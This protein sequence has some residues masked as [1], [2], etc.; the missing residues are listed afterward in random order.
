[1]T[2][3]VCGYCGVQLDELAANIDDTPLGYEV[4]CKNEVECVKRTDQYKIT[5][6]NTEDA[7]GSHIE[8]EEIVELVEWVLGDAIALHST[9]FCEGL[10]LW[11]RSLRG[12]FKAT[13]PEQWLNAITV[14]GDWRITI[15]RHTWDEFWVT[16]YHH[17]I[18]S[19]ATFTVRPT[20]A[21]VTR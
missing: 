8:W 13:T 16:L 6:S 18:P 20:D 9:W 2:A 4:A 7:S 11:N 5:V 15:E 17:D 10:P 12:V 3:L 1:M 14:N 21:E 19:G